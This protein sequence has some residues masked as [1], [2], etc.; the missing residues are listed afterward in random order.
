MNR[1]N[2]IALLMAGVRVKGSQKAFAEHLGISTAYLNDVLHNR[3]EPGE[4]ILDALGIK[5]IVTYEYKEKDSND[6]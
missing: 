5:R 6:D 4:K 1:G 2:L 3:R